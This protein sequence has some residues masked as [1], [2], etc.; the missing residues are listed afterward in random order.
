MIHGTSDDYVKPV[1]GR[2][3][4]LVTDQDKREAHIHF[5][6]LAPIG[7]SLIDAREAVTKTFRD[8]VK[9]CDDWNYEDVRGGLTAAGFECHGLPVWEEATDG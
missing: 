2:M 6:A 3:P 1:N 4:V 7:M 5:L 8:V 9:D